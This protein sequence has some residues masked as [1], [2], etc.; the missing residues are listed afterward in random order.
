MA[1]APRQ[2]INITLPGPTLRLLDR[3]AGKGNRS[4]VIDEAVR[5]YVAIIGAAKLRARLKE[6]AIR[7][8][9]Q[10]RR[11]A[12]DWFTIDEE[13]WNLAAR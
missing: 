8:A 7:R 13:A 5:Q 11:L 6:G 2:R 4:R 12:A 3:V 1:T 10:N 9:E